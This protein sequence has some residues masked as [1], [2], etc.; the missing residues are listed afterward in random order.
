MTQVN[1]TLGICRRCRQLWRMRV[2]REEGLRC[3]GTAHDCGGDVWLPPPEQQAAL[4]AMAV[5]GGWDTVEN[6]IRRLLDDREATIRHIEAMGWK[7][8]EKPRWPK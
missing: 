6:E 2:D 4:E 8:I 1:Y 3:P 5:L 7:Y